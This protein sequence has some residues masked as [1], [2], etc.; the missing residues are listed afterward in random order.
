MSLSLLEELVPPTLRLDLGA[1]VPLDVRELSVREGMN[2]LFSVE[3]VCVSPRVDLDIYALGGR[4]GRFS[5]ERLT[6]QGTE[7]RAFSGVV[8]AFTLVRAEPDGLSTYSL[9][10]VPELWLSSQ[11]RSY[12]VFQQ[13]SDP[14]IALAMLA[15]AGI[16]A[17]VRLGESY[18]R[19]RY[20]TQY[21][22][23]DYAFFARVL[24]SAGV[25]FWFDT[26]IEGGGR[27]VL[28]DTPHKGEA[29]APLPFVARPQA[30]QRQE[31]VTRVEVERN[32]SPGLYEQQDVDFRMP[33]EM[34]LLARRSRGVAVERDLRLHHYNPGSLSFE[35]AGGDTPFAD[36]RG[37][38]RTDLG[39]GA[40]QVEKRLDAKRGD[41]RRCRFV[42]TALDVRPGTVLAFSEHPKS[43]LGVANT[44]LVVA[45]SFT[46]E[47]TGDWMHDC[48]AQFTDVA[49]RPPLSTPRPRVRGVE[50]ATVVGPA[51]EEI[52]TDEFG[53]VRVHFH[54]DREGAP[55]E[56]ASLWV[57]VNQPW[58]GAGFGA[59][60]I[61]RIGQEV[62]VDFLDGDPDR[63]VVVGR[64]F[65]RTNPSPYAL[66]KFQNLQSLRSESTP[67]LPQGAARSGLL[68]GKPAGG[69]DGA[70]EASPQSSPLG[71]GLPFSMS[72]IMEILNGSKFFGALSPNAQTHAWQGSELTMHDEQ[73]KEKMYLQ[74]QKDFHTVVKNN[75]K[76]VVGNSRAE[77]VGTDNVEQIGNKDQFRVASDRTGN[78]NGNQAVVVQNVVYRE[79]SANMLY[80]THTTYGSGA[81]DTVFQADLNFAS[82]AKMNVFDSSIETVLV[83]GASSII[84]RPEGISLNSPKLLFKTGLTASVASSMPSHAAVEAEAAKQNEIARAREELRK[85]YPRQSTPTAA[86]LK[87]RLSRYSLLSDVEKDGLV[88]E[89]MVRRGLAQ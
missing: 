87:G 81:K 46:G 65:T 83:C 36:D 25:S 60:N 62:I 54:W 34:P 61:P 27:L 88:Q 21:A 31:L 56:T 14:D 77:T 30:L 38:Q 48:E 84:I 39:E 70:G 10:L 55:D 11:T 74:A 35:A 29:R 12:R 16:E 79:S 45:A 66:P 17:D 49:R 76:T 8:S 73:G 26:S 32:L 50:T 75:E 64:V 44:M 78:V 68:G 58:G 52:H 23:S 71:G 33:P 18:K 72:Q 43:D 3:L 57:P 6:L 86:S 69:G 41:A 40:A 59:L 7:G 80:A 13:M 89:E 63:P 67:K 15:R 5:I 9:R 51:G 20:R 82:N 85:W 22:E 53:R 1:D 19:R 4:R 24:E 47:A 42:T 2:Q 37:A 28:S